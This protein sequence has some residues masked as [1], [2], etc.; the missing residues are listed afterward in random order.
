MRA[1]TRDEK[2]HIRNQL[3]EAGRRLFGDYG[4][5]KTSV[6][7]LTREVGIS[8]GA[9][10][11]FF[12]SKEALYFAVL[13]REEESIK[14]RLLAEVDTESQQGR[15]LVK[16]LLLT[17]LRLIGENP[18]IRRIYTDEDWERIMRKLP[19]EM[20]EN[21]LKKDNELLKEVLKE[22]K[23]RGVVIQENPEVAAGALRAFF[24]LTLHRQEIGENIYEEVIVRMAEWIATGLADGGKGR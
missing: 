15:E 10:Y 20:V 14:Q 3:L 16:N 18:V 7:E 21:H 2:E 19:P 12:P 1:F 8:Q 23:K 4:F 13:E 9:F 11:L 24:M 17:G 6:A 5:K 22:W